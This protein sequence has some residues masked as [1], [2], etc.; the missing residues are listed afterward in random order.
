MQELRRENETATAKITQLS[1]NVSVKMNEL[2]G[3]KQINDD[4]REKLAD[5]GSEVE[6]L[7]QNE[8]ELNE[9]LNILHEIAGN[10]NSVTKSTGSKMVL[11]TTVSD[12]PMNKEMSQIKSKLDDANKN[13]SILTDEVEELTRKLDN[14]DNFYKKIIDE[15]DVA[16]QE[17]SCILEDDDDV[18]CKLRRLLIKFRSENELKLI[19]ELKSALSSESES[20]QMNMPPLE[21]SGD[22]ADENTAH[23]NVTPNHECDADQPASRKGLCRE[24][25]QCTSKASCQFRH[26]LI[27]KPCRFGSRCRRKAKCLFFHEYEGTQYPAGKLTV[28]GGTGRPAFNVNAYKN[29][30][31][32]EMWTNNEMGGRLVPQNHVAFPVTI[33]VSNKQFIG[34]SGLGVSIPK[35]GF[36]LRGP[37]CS[38]MHTTCEYNH[39]PINKPCRNGSNCPNRETTCLF[40]H[41][42][43][44]SLASPT[45]NRRGQFNYNNHPD[46]EN[47][48]DRT[49]LRAKNC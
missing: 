39:T 35:K 16:I 8:R 30:F 12:D 28:D 24:G 45:N 19:Q 42:T 40:S 25:R 29:G 14:I 34:N 22:E 3:Y 43:E 5:K 26:E 15:K 6:K 10:D 18:K 1:S 41:G 48:I 38:T 13:N 17:Y 46:P 4:L 44:R 47:N 36:C 11:S 9:K 33:P 37:T 21:E 32:N 20:P 49:W 31:Q 23:S 27:N 7:L 2:S